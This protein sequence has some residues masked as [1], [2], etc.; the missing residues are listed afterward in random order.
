MP[1]PEL[2]V[3]A[4]HAD[5]LLGGAA[6]LL[7]IAPARFMAGI[8]PLLQARRSEGLTARVV[9]VEAIYAHYSGGVVDPRAI[10]SFL[11]NARSQLGTRYVLL[12]GGDTY[13]YFDRLGLGSIS[14]VPTIYGRTHAVVNHAPLDHAFAD[15][16]DDGQI[17]LSVGRLPVRTIA[18]LGFLIDKIL[19][20]P[21]SPAHSVLFAAERANA[22]EGADYATEVEEVISALQP[23][24]QLGAQRVYLDNYAAGSAGVAAAR[25]DLRAAINAGQRVVGYYGHG[26]PTVWS[27]EQLLQSGQLNAL[28]G[29]AATTAPVVA[30]FGCWGGY[31]VA[32]QFNTMSHG[33][34]NAGQRGASGMFASSGLTDHASDRRMA[35]ELMQ[36]LTVPGVRLGDALLNSKQFLQDQAPE[37][38]DVIRGLTLFGDPSMRLP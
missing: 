5:P 14:D 23:D 30:E 38:G 35:L 24:W 25:N 29:N 37:Y 22:A 18:E 7:A 33:W 1:Q 31:F 2:R 4:L 15:L 6:E 3:A 8:E 19:A 9:D 32:P 20:A 13:D 36:R 12:V 34:L 16:N 17:E 27:R 11:T 26:S 21:A 28:L 10:R